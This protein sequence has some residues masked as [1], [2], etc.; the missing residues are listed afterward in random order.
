M[1]HEFGSEI[2]GNDTLEI[3][4]TC[5]S[6]VHTTADIGLIADVGAQD[7]RAIN[8]AVIDGGIGQG[9]Y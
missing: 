6:A 1:C 9:K 2:Y 4:T 8:L 3:L 5:K 7:A